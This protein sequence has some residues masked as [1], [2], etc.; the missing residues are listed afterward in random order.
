VTTPI[1]DQIGFSRQE[2]ANCPSRGTNI[3][4]FKIRVEHQYRLVHSASTTGT[5]ILLIF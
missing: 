3:D 1:H 2:Q 4:R 5:I